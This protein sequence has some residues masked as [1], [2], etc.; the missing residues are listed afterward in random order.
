MNGKKID[1]EKIRE[2]LKNPTLIHNANIEYN[3]EN[4]N[5]IEQ[6]ETFEGGQENLDK[7]KELMKAVSAEERLRRLAQP[8]GEIQKYDDERYGITK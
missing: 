2:N 7:F 8:M 6:T 4:N 3:S 1:L 5:N